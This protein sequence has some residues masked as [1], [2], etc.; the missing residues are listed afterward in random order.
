MSVE[1]EFSNTP[2]NLDAPPDKRIKRAASVGKS[3]VIPGKRVVSSK[4]REK[5]RIIARA[6]TTK[7]SCIIRGVL[8][9]RAE[10]VWF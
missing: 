5:P 4:Y 2:A 10:T 3:D 6:N 8:S 7:A 1:I 9:N